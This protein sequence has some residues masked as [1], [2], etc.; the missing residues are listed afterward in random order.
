MKLKSTVSSIGKG[1][2]TSLEVIHNA[3]ISARI[4]EIDEEIERLQEEKAKLE[5]DKIDY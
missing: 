2:L 5:N 1:L 4:R 3:P